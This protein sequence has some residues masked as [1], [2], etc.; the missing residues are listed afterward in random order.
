MKGKYYTI[1]I[2][3]EDSKEIKKFRVSTAWFTFIKIFL[4]V[5][6]AITGVFIYKMGHVTKTLVRYEKMRVTN[7]QLIKQNANYEELFNRMDS[8]WVLEERIQNLLGT[9]VENDSNKINSL[10]DRNK[11]AHTPSEKIDVDYEGIHGWIPQEEKIRLERIPNV[12]PVV[13]IISKKFSEENEHLG[14][15]FSAQAGNPVFASGSGSVEFAGQKE[16][17]GNTVIINHQNGYVSSYSHLKEIRTKKGRSV[18]KGDVIGTIGTTG[19][20]NGPHLHY[21]IT[22]DG[23]ELD[24]EKFF[25]Y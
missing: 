15:D 7:A 25:N 24:P 5:L 11:F 10:I 22:K 12:L 8:L 20:T 9:F 4:V 16:E 17:L 21:T 19:N 2:I 6:I 1:Q 13:G 14:T 3:P 23:K 18:S